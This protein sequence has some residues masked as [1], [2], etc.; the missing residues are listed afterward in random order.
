MNKTQLIGRLTG[1]CDL[2]YTQSAN[3]VAIMQNGLAVRKKYVREG[4]HDADFFKIKA[5]GKMAELMNKH[6][7]KGN[8]AGIVGRLEV[9]RWEDDKGKH[10]Q[11]VIVVEDLTFIGSK[12]EP[13]GA[14]ES[15]VVPEEEDDLPF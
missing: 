14:A 5:F 13:A 4:E 7:S 6:L 12:Q 10:S 1:N 8:Q 9:E 2:K 11:V 15:I 3:P